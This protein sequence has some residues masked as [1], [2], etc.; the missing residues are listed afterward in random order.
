MAQPWDRDFRAIFDIKVNSRGVILSA[1]D[2][3]KWEFCAEA[4]QWAVDAVNG[5]KD[6]DEFWT[7]L[8]IKSNSVHTK[9]EF[10]DLFHITLN[11]L[12]QWCKR[13][14]NHSGS[15]GRP[16]KINDESMQKVYEKIREG[17]QANNCRPSNLGKLLTDAAV[18]TAQSRGKS[19]IDCQKIINNGVSISAQLTYVDEYGLTCRLAQKTNVA[20]ELALAC[21]R[22]LCHWITVYASANRFLPSFKKWNSDQSMVGVKTDGSGTRVWICK[23]EAA[24][25]MEREERLVVTTAEVLIFFFNM[26][27][28]F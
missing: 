2:L 14:Y 24:E 27:C 13:K 11:T 12:R 7:R 9:R 16:K 8:N 19:V 10:C 15:A 25:A 20:R 3:S 26:L 23:E 22:L 21:L 1:N 28:A 18:E 6:E 4:K 5:L 17:G